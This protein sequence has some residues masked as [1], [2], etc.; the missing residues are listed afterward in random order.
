[1]SNSRFISVSIGIFLTEFI[2]S[3]FWPFLLRADLF[4]IFALAVFFLDHTHK[5]SFAVF[6]SIAIVFDFWSGSHFG[7][8]TLTLLVTILAIFLTKKVVLIDNRVNFSALLW[9]TGFYYFHLLIKGILY[10]LGR[11]FIFPKLSFI[12]LMETVLW[13]LVILI[14]YTRVSYEKRVSHF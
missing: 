8:L 1:M 2:L 11:Q 10:N 6:I 9:L 5:T 13:I 12:D 14:V 4:I 3:I 7:N